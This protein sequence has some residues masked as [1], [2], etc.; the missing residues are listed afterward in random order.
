MVWRLWVCTHD[1]LWLTA[2]VLQWG[3]KHWREKDTRK[4]HPRINSHQY[5][6]SLSCNLF[7]IT[8]YYNF[9][10]GANDGTL[11]NQLKCWGPPSAHHNISLRGR[12]VL[13]EVQ[14]IKESF[15]PTITEG[16]HV[17]LSYLPAF[18][19]TLYSAPFSWYTRLPALRVDKNTDQQ[20]LYMFYPGRNWTSF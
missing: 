9:V 15:F 5:F 7:K 20:N 13:T 2:L 11:E 3:W 6:W 18:R 10:H 16:P 8:L 14:E 19:S 4:S 1:L 17:Q 12:E